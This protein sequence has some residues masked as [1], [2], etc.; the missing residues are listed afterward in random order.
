MLPFGGDLPEAPLA[1]LAPSLYDPYR[2]PLSDKDLFRALSLGDSLRGLDELAIE[3]VVRILFSE[4]LPL[5]LLRLC[6]DSVLDPSFLPRLSEAFDN[7]GIDKSRLN[8]CLS[9]AT[10]SYPNAVA[11]ALKAKGL[12]YGLSVYDYD[13]ENVA[14]IIKTKPSYALI[15]PELLRKSASLEFLTEIVGLLPPLGVAPL[16]EAGKLG[17]SLSALSSGQL[18]NC[19]RKEEEA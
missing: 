12:G 3:E 19:P 18:Q 17:D 7:A 6:E 13:G 10:L 2:G 16:I 11:F 1:L 8:L 14:S 4:T 5:L 15:K 9:C